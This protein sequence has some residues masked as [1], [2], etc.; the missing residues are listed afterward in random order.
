MTETA[1]KTYDHSEPRDEAG[2]WTSGG[3]TSADVSSLSVVKHWKGDRGR[4]GREALKKIESGSQYVALHD[5]TGKLKALATYVE[6][7]EDASTTTHYPTGAV[8]VVDRLAT[9]ESGH[10]RAIMQRLIDLAAH[11]KQGLGLVA[12]KGAVGF[13]EKLGMNRIG[14]H[15]VF[16]WSA[17]EVKARATSTKSLSSA[18]EPPSGVFV[19]RSPEQRA[20]KPSTNP[21]SFKS[22]TYT[23]ADFED[24]L[25]RCRDEGFLS[26]EEVADLRARRLHLVYTDFPLPLDEGIPD[27]LTEEDVRASKRRLGVL[28]LVA[29]AARARRRDEMQNVL[30]GRLRA[31]ADTSSTSSVRAWQTAMRDGITAHIL[32]QAML[33]R[34]A[35]VANH[36]PAPDVLEH[37]NDVIQEQTARLSRFADYRA[38]RSLVGRPLT[39]EY[40]AARA[41]L[42]TGQGRAEWFKGAEESAAE[43][44][45]G[46]VVDYIANDDASTC[47]PCKDAEQ[48]SPYLPSAG[49]FPGEV[50]EGRGRCRCERQLRYSPGEARALGGYIDLER[51]AA[52][53]DAVIRLS[54]GKSY[55]PTE[56]RDD[57]GRWTSDSR[58]T[59]QHPDLT[60]RFPNLTTEQAHRYYALNT[61]FG[62]TGDE[63]KE[64]RVL[65]KLLMGKEDEPAPTKHE[66]AHAK[67]VLRAIAGDP[68][69]LRMAAA[70]SAD[71][72]SDDVANVTEHLFSAGVVDAMVETDNAALN[73]IFSGYLEAVGDEGYYVDGGVHGKPSPARLK[74]ERKWYGKEVGGIS[75]G[76]RYAEKYLTNFTASKKSYDPNEARDEAGKWTSSGAVAWK[77][78]MTPEEADEW[79]KGSAFE[80]REFYHGT[81]KVGAGGI[82]ENGFDAD[83]AKNGRAAGAGVYMTTSKEYAGKYSESSETT[84]LLKTHVKN[85]K[86]LTA[87]QSNQLS[88]SAEIKARA[89]RLQEAARLK[90]GFTREE[91]LDADPYGYAGWVGKAVTEHLAGQ[92]HDSILITPEDES[93]QILLVF[94]PKNVVVIKR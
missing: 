68:V 16:H 28:L 62:L 25:A 70:L 54:T 74:W 50:C 43:T 89:D 38:A 7:N 46:W 12:D 5:P 19:A 23:H 84:L 67:K 71:G 65:E 29:L 35:A 10:G 32:D 9:A 51:E 47:Q 66:I 61:K 24:F 8:L 80:D 55:D 94:D 20:E 30:E 14:T 69:A 6:L 49:A 1:Y 59:E 87:S 13:Y 2:R 11:N 81:S 31:L 85:P 60:G 78:T 86:P 37:L 90:G 26:P 3:Y 21:L 18:S 75:K 57:E 53:R 64:L 92:G 22:A 17:E 52:E 48:D 76:V 63:D 82:A 4:I 45:D 27:D 44:D 72:G 58:S 42:Y 79:A 15:D 41:A 73:K 33:G 56:P 83:N 36:D 93:K 34:G 88:N 91:W 40:L 39:P 77:P